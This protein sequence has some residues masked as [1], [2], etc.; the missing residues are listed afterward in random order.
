MH[1]CPPISPPPSQRAY[2]DAWVE[3][4]TLR[5]ILPRLHT[6][7]GLLYFVDLPGRPESFAH[8]VTDDAPWAD[9][10]GQVHL[11]LTRE[12][13]G[14][15]PAATAAAPWA[16]HTNAPLRPGWADAELALLA[17]QHPNVAHLLSGCALM[18]VMAAHYGPEPPG[19]PSLLEM[20][21]GLPAS[22]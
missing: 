16:L 22:S 4:A 2:V 13:G 19:C 14:P 12:R 1:G 9:G 10:G 18:G 3:P 15:T 20:L 17:R 8:N 11:N 6:I 21:L 7:P 5:Y